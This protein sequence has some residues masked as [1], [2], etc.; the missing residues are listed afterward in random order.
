[1]SAW[2]KGITAITIDNAEKVE[3]RIAKLESTNA[4]TDKL[5]I[6]IYEDYANAVIDKDRFQL[7]STHNQEKQ[8]QGK[9]EV[10]QARCF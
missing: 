6:K 1:M 2:A 9:A 7:L 3:K 10:E 5:Y 8:T 4:E